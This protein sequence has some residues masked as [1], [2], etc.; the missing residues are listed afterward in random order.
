MIAWHYTKG[1]HLQ[2]IIEDGELRPA[3]EGVSRSEKPI[4]WFSTNQRWEPTAGIGTIENGKLRTAT[5]EETAEVAG[6]LARIGVDTDETDLLDWRELKE[7]SG[8]SSQTAQALYRAAI[9]SGARP[10]EWLG[11]FSPVAQ[12][13]WVAVDVFRDGDWARVFP[14]TGEQIKEWSEE[15]A[16]GT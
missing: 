8:M 6:G 14:A 11:R 10:G 1:V 7:L 3:T 4:I 15:A 13:E 2:K 9:G 5:M 12:D 16:K